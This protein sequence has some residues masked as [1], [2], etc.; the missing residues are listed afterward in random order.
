MEEEQAVTRGVLEECQTRATL[1]DQL[2]RDLAA[3][4]AETDV[5]HQE[6]KQ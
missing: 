4:T 1:I 3:T 5:Y 6:H 2:E